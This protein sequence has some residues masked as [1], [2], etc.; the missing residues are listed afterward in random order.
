MRGD[1]PDRARSQMLVAFG[2][3]VAELV[4]HADQ[5]DIAFVGIGIMRA[6]EEGGNAPPV[7]RFHHP[8]GREFI[9]CLSHVLSARLFSSGLLYRP[10]EWRGLLFSSVAGALVNED[11]AQDGRQPADRHRHQ[12]RQARGGE[13][14]ADG[15]RQG[16][17][18]DHLCMPPTPAAVPESSGLSA[19]APT[20]ALGSVSPFD[21]VTSIIG[22]NSAIG[23][24]MPLSAQ[25]S[26]MPR[27]DTMTPIPIILTGPRRAASRAERK[28]PLM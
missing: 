19:M 4:R 8:L 10:P 16:R 18:Q 21:S 22:A 28:F 20:V 17:R 12:H 3:A 24:L 27:P 25:N 7:E 5:R 6:A 2:R 9:G 14:R 11:G 13:Q 26:R 1:M 23:R 15:R